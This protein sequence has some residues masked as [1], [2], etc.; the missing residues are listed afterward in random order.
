MTVALRIRAQLTY[1]LISSIIDEQALPPTSQ[2]LRLHT[3]TYEQLFIIYEQLSFP[4]EKALRALLPL[5][6][7]PAELTIH[8][9]EPGPTHC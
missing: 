3:S 1:H 2:A 7:R 4:P 8:H 5:T 9:G 6:H